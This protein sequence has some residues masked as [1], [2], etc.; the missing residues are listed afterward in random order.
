MKVKEKS[1][2]T[3]DVIIVLRSGQQIKVNGVSARPF[4]ECFRDAPSDQRW[5][6]FFEEEN[7]DNPEF[8]FRINEVA[9]VLSMKAE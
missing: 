9:A 1:G 6:T 5:A 4:I 3:R 8:L 2:V 7:Q